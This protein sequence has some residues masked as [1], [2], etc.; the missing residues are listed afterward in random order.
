MKLYYII[1]IKYF[2][3]KSFSAFTINSFSEAISFPEN[4]V[5]KSQL[6]NFPILIFDTATFPFSS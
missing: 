5:D 2:V 3:R 6:K 1:S 4:P